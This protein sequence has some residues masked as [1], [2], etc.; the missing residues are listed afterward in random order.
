MLTIR[1]AL[2]ST[3]SA[4]LILSVYFSIIAVFLLYAFFLNLS[5][6]PSFVLF[7]G[8]SLRS[9]LRS[10]SLSWPCRRW[11]VWQIYSPQWEFR[12][13]L[14][15]IHCHLEVLLGQTWPDS[16]SSVER[17]YYYNWIFKYKQYVSKYLCSNTNALFGLV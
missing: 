4:H 15:P 13:R 8:A 12:A 17:I 10:V 9:K 6:R 5:S 1:P 11:A 2:L 7:T 14:S 3:S 16:V